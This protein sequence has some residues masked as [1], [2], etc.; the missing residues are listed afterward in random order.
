VRFWE[1]YQK[2]GNRKKSL[3]RFNKLKKSEIEL[4]KIHLP[5]YVKST[6]DKQYRKNF[7]TYLFNDCWNDE[8][9]GEKEF[10]RPNAFQQPIKISKEQQKVADDRLKAMLEASSKTV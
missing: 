3:Q 10:I 9:I 7:E 5:K 8:V 4:I 6:P 2:K 1:I